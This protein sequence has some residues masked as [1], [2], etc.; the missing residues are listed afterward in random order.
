M[1]EEAQEEV[2]ERTSK[3][4]QLKYDSYKVNRSVATGLFKDELIELL[5]APDDCWEYR[6][7]K[8]VKKIKRF[9]IP[10]APNRHF[11]RK[12]KL[13]RNF[14]LKKRKAV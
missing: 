3:N 2:D 12:H 4:D 13:F 8:L 6:Y 11:E 5:L 1:I 7:N 14:F 9:T 10:V